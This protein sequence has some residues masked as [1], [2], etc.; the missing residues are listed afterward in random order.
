MI[1]EHALFVKGKHQMSLHG[2]CRQD[3][4]SDREDAHTYP[5]LSPSCAHVLY[6]SFQTLCHTQHGVLCSLE[7]DV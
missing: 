3:R 5:V 6:F 4:E 7:V 1:K 2:L